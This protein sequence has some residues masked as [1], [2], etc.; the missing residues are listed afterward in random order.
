MKR[1]EAE[2][3]LERSVEVFK[4]P[5]TDVPSVAVSLL[6]AREAASARFRWASRRASISAQ[7]FV[8]AVETFFWP[9][10]RRL[11]RASLL[12]ASRSSKCNVW[13]WRVRRR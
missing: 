11:F 3:D 6:E 9:V 5:F 10:V 1:D 8:K 2:W 12:E 13:I 4:E 7:R